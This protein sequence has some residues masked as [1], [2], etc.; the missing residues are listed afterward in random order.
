ML[1]HISNEIISGEK[2]LLAFL[3]NLGSYF[4]MRT[5]VHKTSKSG[6]CTSRQGYT[7]QEKEMHF[8]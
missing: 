4:H 1:W 7:N 6:L 3:S 2:V 5:S 8:Y